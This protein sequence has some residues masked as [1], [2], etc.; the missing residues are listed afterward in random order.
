L[1]KP[2]RQ[3]N[4]VLNFRAKQTEE[5]KEIWA[6]TTRA[7]KAFGRLW[8]DAHRVGIVK[9]PKYGFQVWERKAMKEQVENMG[10]I[11]VLALIYLF[12]RPSDAAPGKY[13]I[14]PWA[15]KRSVRVFTRNDGISEMLAHDFIKGNRAKG[16]PAADENGVRRLFVAE[17]EGWEG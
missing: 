8:S 14:C 15:D 6:E 9:N 12:F 16:I 7:L 17:L 10:L 5:E 4:K 1:N 2:L 11:A 3:R 13:E